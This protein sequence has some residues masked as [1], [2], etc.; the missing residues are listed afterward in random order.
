M[1]SVENKIKK[2]LGQLTK[3]GGQIVFKNM[4]R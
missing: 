4:N 1:E 2:K 3:H